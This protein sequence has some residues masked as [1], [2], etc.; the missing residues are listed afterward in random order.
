MIE[1]IL[2]TKDYGIKVAIDNWLV[3]FTKWFIRAKR[4]KIT[5]WK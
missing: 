4:I 3:G 1:F 2:Q 5:Y